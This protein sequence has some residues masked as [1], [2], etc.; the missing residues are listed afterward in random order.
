MVWRVPTSFTA[1]SYSS[2]SQEH[3]DMKKRE[4]TRSRDVRQHRRAKMVAIEWQ[5]MRE[6][7]AVLKTSRYY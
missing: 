6:S 1:C 7:I 4:P 5:K 2:L 3:G